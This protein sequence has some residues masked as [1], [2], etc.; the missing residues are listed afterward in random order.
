MGSDDDFETLEKDMLE[1]LD[2]NLLG[3]LKTVQAFLPLIRNGKEKKVVA[4]STGMADID[5]INAT[6]IPYATPY[7]VS[8]AAL[9]IAVAKYSA[10]Y[11]VDGILFLAIS[12]GYVSTERNSCKSIFLSLIFHFMY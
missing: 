8:K 12:P 6:D 2:I 3:Y 5:L 1:S 11:K 9:N 7:A 4:I 10:L